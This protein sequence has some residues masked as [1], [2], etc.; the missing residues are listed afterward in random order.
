LEFWY[1]APVVVANPLYPDDEF[2]L[3]MILQL[4]ST[5]YNTWRF[6]LGPFIDAEEYENL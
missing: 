2:N 6:T 1:G 4:A 3:S 5:N